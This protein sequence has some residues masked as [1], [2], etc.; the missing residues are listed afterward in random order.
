[1]AHDFGSGSSRSRLRIRDVASQS[2][3]DFGIERSALGR[4]ELGT[5]TVKIIRDGDGMELI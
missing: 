1:V 3:N 2:I 5:L 4:Y